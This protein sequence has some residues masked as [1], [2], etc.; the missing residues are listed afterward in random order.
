MSFFIIENIK[1]YL[2][3]PALYNNAGLR[4]LKLMFKNPPLVTA[5]RECAL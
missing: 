4:Q 1:K 3:C 5:D 2:K